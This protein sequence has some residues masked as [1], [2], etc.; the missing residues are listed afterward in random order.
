MSMICKDSPPPARSLTHGAALEDRDRSPESQVDSA[1]RSRYW[2]SIL[3]PVYN[4]DRYLEDCLQSIAQ[5]LLPDVEIIVLDDASEDQ[6]GKVIA[7][8][9]NRFG[10]TLRVIRLTANGGLSAARNRLLAEARGD[11]CWFIDGDDVM[12]TGAMLALHHVV[13]TS[14]ADLV[15][16]DFRMQREH[17]GLK[18]RLR[19][20]AHRRTFACQRRLGL[21]QRSALIEGI[22]LG[23]QLHA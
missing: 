9:S 15:L 4:V 12:C 7:R 23:G 11:Y 1:R 14:A 19:G 22:L 13:Q 16:C 3:I 8:F 10:T 21:T 5:Q 20:E 18:H 6:S 17:F 2:L